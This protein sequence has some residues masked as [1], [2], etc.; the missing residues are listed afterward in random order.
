M[1]IYLN[2]FDLHR[3]VEKVSINNTGALVISFTDT[4]HLKGSYQ[5]FSDVECIQ[6]SKVFE[7]KKP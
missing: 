4:K 3:D 2:N 6:I 5:T 7:L 1:H